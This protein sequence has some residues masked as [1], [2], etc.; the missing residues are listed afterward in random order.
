MNLSLKEHIETDF[1]PKLSHH[2]K[3]S[4]Q[5]EQQ[6]YTLDGGLILVPLNKNSGFYSTRTEY[7]EF[8]ELA[9]NVLLSYNEKVVNPNDNLE[10]LEDYS[11]FFEK[12][13]DSITDL[14]PPSTI[15][16]YIPICYPKICLCSEPDSSS[17]LSI[18]FGRKN[19]NSKPCIAG[20]RSISFDSFF[21]QGLL[22]IKKI[23]Y[24]SNQRV[25]APPNKSAFQDGVMYKSIFQVI[26]RY[27]EFS[28]YFE[29]PIKEMPTQEFISKLLKGINTLQSQDCKEEC[30]RLI[31]GEGKNREAPFRDWFVTFLSGSYDYVNSEPEKGNGRID[32]KVEDKKLGTKI[33]EFKGWWNNDKDQV[34]SQIMNY[35][36]DFNYDGYII[37][38]NHNKKKNILKDYQSIIK[39]P[40]MNYVMNSVQEIEFDDT[41]FKY[42]QTHHYDGIRTKVLTHIILN[43]Y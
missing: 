7:H 4:E 14:T 10:F 15:L 36:T 23:D 34:V 38:I 11:I 9:K 30:I 40:E 22:R 35:L 39:T 41:K 1:R 19:S 21:G 17:N 28:E 27:A 25:L 32:L 24:E 42:F 29:S 20:R 33:I 13:F 6:F 43:V 5:F 16:N 26:E 2:I 18:G 3:Y 31:K 37:I 8:V 12:G